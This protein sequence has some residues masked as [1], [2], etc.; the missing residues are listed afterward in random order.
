MSIS[1]SLCAIFAT[2]VFLHID[3]TVSGIVACSTIIFGSIIIT[4]IASST[5]FR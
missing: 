2:I 4:P 5:A 3:D 1:N